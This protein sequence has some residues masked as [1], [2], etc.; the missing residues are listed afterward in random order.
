M[1][2]QLLDPHRVAYG[3][4][5][6]L[7]PAGQL[8][9]STLDLAFVAAVN[10]WVEDRWLRQDPRLRG[11]IVVPTE[12]PH[13]AVGEIER[14]AGDSRFFQIQFAGRLSEPLGRS[15][16]WP[17]Y[18]VAS[19]YGLPIA[20]HAFG[21]GHSPITGAGWPSFYIEDHVS[22]T[23]T[24]AAQATSLVCEGVFVRFPQL[25]VVSVE[26]GFGWV[27]ALMRRMDKCWELMRDEV[28]ALTEPPSTY[29][30]RHI[31]FSTQPIEEPERAGQFR[32]LLDRLQGVRV[33]YSS[34][35]P[36][37]DYDDPVGFLPEPVDHATM[38]AIMHDNAAQLYDRRIA[39]AV[40]SAP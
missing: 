9:N 4:L 24:M 39:L 29:L 25:R 6:P 5:L 30:Q 40:Q 15:K 7:T 8:L 37:W 33:V 36:H 17:I 31:W 13:L 16:Y 34:D 21:A 23:H 19:H 10:D 3:L 26:N 1:R 20:T 22:P 18:E 14:H 27:P 35:Y 28:P 2:E 11:S 38:R 32:A 12:Y